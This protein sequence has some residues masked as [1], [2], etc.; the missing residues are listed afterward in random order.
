MK[1]NEKAIRDREQEMK[2]VGIGQIKSNSMLLGAEFVL[3]CG[4]T[5]PEICRFPT[6]LSS[7][8]IMVQMK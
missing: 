2:G 7:F 3:T 6:Y 8:I 4:F 1:G 5:Y